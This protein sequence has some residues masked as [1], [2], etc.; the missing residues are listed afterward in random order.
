M[1]LLQAAKRALA[2]EDEQTAEV[3]RRDLEEAVSAFEELM[4]TSNGVVA[5]DQHQDL[6][7]YVVALMVAAANLVH[8]DMPAAE[9]QQAIGQALDDINALLPQVADPAPSS[10]SEAPDGLAMQAALD[11]VR[12]RVAFDSATARW[13]R[14]A[15]PEAI[16]QPAEA[17]E[18]GR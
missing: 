16:Q 2:A 6:P 4:P 14:M 5:E 18:T 12:T 9:A 11:V 10:T 1:D 8:G 3:C 17:V 7:A 13:R 15:P